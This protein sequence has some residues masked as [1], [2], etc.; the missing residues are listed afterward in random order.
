[1][2]NID[3]KKILIS[4]EINLKWSKKNA[5][6]AEFLLFCVVKGCQNNRLCL[7][8]V[9]THSGEHIQFLNT[10]KSLSK[11]TNEMLNNNKKIE[12]IRKNNKE[13]E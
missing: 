10:Y 3:K 9:K 11:I 5:N 13:K 8:C 12:E 7:E 1:M 4:I 6:N 2:R